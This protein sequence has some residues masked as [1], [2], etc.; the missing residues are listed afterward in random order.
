MPGM[1]GFVATH[2][3]KSEKPEMPVIAL[4]AYSLAEDRLKAMEAGC[5]SLITKPVDRSVLYREIIKTLKL[6]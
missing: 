6:N 3:I 5:N 1:D 2:L 4:T